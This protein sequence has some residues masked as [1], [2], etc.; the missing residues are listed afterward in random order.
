MPVASLLQLN[1]TKT[2][3]MVV[4]LRRTRTPLT[5]VSILGPNVDFV[6]HSKYL[7]VF[8][9]NKLDWTKNTLKFFTRGDRDAS[10]F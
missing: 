10:I 1:T 8:I 3:E 4:D 6:E 2:K 9:D 7:G 5:P